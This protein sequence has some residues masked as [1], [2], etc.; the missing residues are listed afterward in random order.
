M[1]L[2]STVS[3]TSHCAS[4]VS[5]VYVPASS[6]TRLW[7]RSW[8][9]ASFFFRS[10]LRP[11]W[12]A[13]LFLIQVTLPLG[14]EMVQAKVTVSPSNAIVLCGFSN[15]S[16][17]NTGQ[18]AFICN[19]FRSA[20]ALCFHSWFL[21][22]TVTQIIHKIIWQLKKVE[23]LSCVYVFLASSQFYFKSMSSQTNITNT[24]MKIT[25]RI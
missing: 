24:G 1:F 2:P 5:Q 7:I 10:Y 9:N 8:W 3:V 17:A 18:V 25:Y 16:T 19:L 23:L 6:A 12:R 20:L 4:P 13:T 15:I 22:T 14:S 11:A 21:W